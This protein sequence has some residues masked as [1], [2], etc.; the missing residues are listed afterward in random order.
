MTM[1][2][3]LLAAAAV[4]AVA[5]APVAASAATLVYEGSTYT[6]APISSG[7]GTFSGDT[8]FEFTVGAA[9]AATGQFAII[10]Q[11]AD[12]FLYKGVLGTT[13]KW[14]TSDMSQAVTLPNGATEKFT[15]TLTD[16]GSWDV[17]VKF[18]GG[19]G[20]GSYALGSIPEPATWAL[21]LIGV[22]GV[23]GAMRRRARL[24]LA[25]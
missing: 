13:Y 19:V 25:A 5:A 20:T 18:D 17:F 8:V 4:S 14:G 2:T 6:V 23:G 15:E 9:D 16:A 22:A 11:G 7:S 1:K 12:P 21:M 10:G 24:A 3:L